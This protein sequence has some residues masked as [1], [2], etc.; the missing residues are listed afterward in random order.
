MKWNVEVTAEWSYEID[1]P[2]L[3]IAEDQARAWAKQ[4]CRHVVYICV[5]AF[6]DDDDDT[7]I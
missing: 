1:A 5:E 3:Q 7:E 4:E 2:T 6:A